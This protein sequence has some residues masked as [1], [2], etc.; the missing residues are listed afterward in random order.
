MSPAVT[1]A[2]GNKICSIACV[3]VND[4]TESLA[5]ELASK[6]AAAVL[7]KLIQDVKELGA[8]AEFVLL[9]R[10]LHHLT[11]RLTLAQAAAAVREADVDDPSR[12]LHDVVC[13]AAPLGLDMQLVDLPADPLWHHGRSCPKGVKM[14]VGHTYVFS[15]DTDGTV[16][17]VEYPSDGV[18]ILVDTKLDSSSL[19]PCAFG[20]LTLPP[21][22][23]PVFV[24][25]KEV[26]QEDNGL[27]KILRR[28]AVEVAT[29]AALIPLDCFLQVR[30]VQVTEKHVRLAFEKLEG[31]TFDELLDDVE[32]HECWA[33]EPQIIGALLLVLQSYQKLNKVGYCQRDAKGANLWLSRGLD[34]RPKVVVIDS[35]ACMKVG[36]MPDARAH[37]YTNEAWQIKVLRDR[38]E[39]RFGGGS[40][41]CTPFG[42]NLDM[43][44]RQC[45]PGEQAMVFSATEV[46]LRLMGR[47]D[48][49]WTVDCDSTYDDVL[50]SSAKCNLFDS[51]HEEDTGIAAWFGRVAI[52]GSKRRE[53]KQPPAALPPGPLPQVKSANPWATQWRSSEFSAL[54]ER[55]GENSDKALGMDLRCVQG[56]LIVESLHPGLLVEWN[57]ANP[58]QA[59]RKGDR[60]VQVNGAWDDAEE[61]QAELQKR[62]PLHIR[63]RREV[64]LGAPQARKERVPMPKQ[65]DQTGAQYSPEF[66]HLMMTLRRRSLS[67]GGIDA[68]LDLAQAIE[69]L[70]DFVARR[71]KTTDSACIE[72]FSSLLVKVERLQKG[73]PKGLP[74]PL[75]G[76]LQS[77]LQGQQLPDISSGILP[78]LAEAMGIVPQ[79]EPI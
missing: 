34:S 11:R 52:K 64:V 74:W 26:P 6:A 65:A 71:L 75:P 67:Q 22:S 25:E 17:V 3:D 47:G 9:Q 24:K 79:A 76:P 21:A 40:N 68:F 55:G 69:L 39:W 59:I 28:I 20:T 8:K 66:L 50:Y 18:R 23:M 56:D 29:C 57:K 44:T 54:I 7:D 32:Q 16:P 53:R 62:E 14:R 4:Q 48:I 5:K 78:Q 77:L 10:T 42:A 2:G 60:I 46:A 43:L 33:S 37:G 61:I 49:V 70:Q 31:Q 58:E 27:D 51:G 12:A 35:D 19:N 15:A 38:Q 36:H 45:L 1:C 41:L 73:C 72:S 30:A 13:G 63:L